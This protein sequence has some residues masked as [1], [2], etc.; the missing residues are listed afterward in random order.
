MLNVLLAETEDVVC[1]ASPYWG[2]INIFSIKLT[3]Q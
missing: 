1:E 3:Q 2:A